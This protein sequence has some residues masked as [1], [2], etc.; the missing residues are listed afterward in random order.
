MQSGSED[1]ARTQKPGWEN[2]PG[3]DLDARYCVRSDGNIFV[4]SIG[5]VFDGIVQIMVW[6]SG[7]WE[8]Y[9]DIYT[10]HSLFVYEIT[11]FCNFYY[12]TGSRP[13]HIG[14]EREALVA[15]IEELRSLINEVWPQLKDLFVFKGQTILCFVVYYLGLIFTLSLWL[16]EGERGKLFHRRVPSKS[17][18]H[19]GKVSPHILCPY[20]PWTR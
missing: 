9:T 1:D 5:V 6:N 3:R 2:I 13:R 4:Q 20:S 10:V 8:Y 12:P 18:W 14:H 11:F 19:P 16:P 17:D 7:D 15:R